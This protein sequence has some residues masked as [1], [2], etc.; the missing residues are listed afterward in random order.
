[1]VDTLYASKDVFKSSSGI[2][3]TNDTQDAEVLRALTGASRGIDRM[4]G[5]R[6]WVDDAPNPRN[7]S[8]SNRITQTQQGEQ[9]LLLNGWDIAT[10]AGL[11]VSTGLIGGTFSPL[12][13]YAYYPDKA[14]VDGWPIEGIL[15]PLGLWTV[16]PGFRVQITARWGWLTVPDDIVQATL[17]LARRLFKRKDS[18]AGVLG[19]TDWVVNLA[20]KDPDVVQLIERFVLHGFG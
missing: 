11:I 15:L 9:L 17:I 18:P 20:K 8:T 1:V 5:R 16:L 12:S 19:S 3:L 6:F 13:G 14:E 10:S 4:T 7:L 2:P